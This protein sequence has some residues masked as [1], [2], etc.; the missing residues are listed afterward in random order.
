MLETP[1]LDGAM[2]PGTSNTIS[3]RDFGSLTIAAGVLSVLPGAAR[4]ATAKAV[5]ETRSR[6]RNL[7]LVRQII[8][9]GFNQGDL[10]VADAICAEKT[11]EHEYLAETGESGPQ[12][13]KTAI[14]ETRKAVQNLHL[15]IDDFAESGDKVWTRSTCRGIEARSGKAVAILVLDVFRFSE[16]KLVEH[17]GVPDRFAMLHQVGLIPSSAG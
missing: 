13:L 8:E 3:R 16:G 2:D 9:R 11:S 6:A 4:A 12:K 10:A 5:R 7:E 1:Q 15:T 14:R 17:W